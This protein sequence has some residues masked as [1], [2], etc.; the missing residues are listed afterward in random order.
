[1]ESGGLFSD[2]LL[3]LVFRFVE[4]D[5]SVHIVMAKPQHAV[6]QAG[7]HVRHRGDSFRGAEFG[8]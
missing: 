5:S 2:S 4:F 7:E 1:M 6:D 8:A 3:V